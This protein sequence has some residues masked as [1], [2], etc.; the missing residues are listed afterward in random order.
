MEEA[1]S[2]QSNSQVEKLEDK[3]AVMAEEEQGGE[4]LCASELEENEQEAMFNEDLLAIDA[5]EEAKDEHR[6]KAQM[7]R[8]DIEHQDAP[9]PIHSREEDW[10]EDVP[11]PSPEARRARPA[12]APEAPTQ[13]EINE[14]MLT[15]PPYKP[16]CEFCN[17]CRR[18]TAPHRRSDEES[19]DIPFM[20]AD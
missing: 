2:P 6:E 13:D 4:K 3:A 19:R 18:P 5:R 7:A 16:W 9:S 14:H 12:R 20:S 15:H 8:E 10:P 11:R 1:V 17:A